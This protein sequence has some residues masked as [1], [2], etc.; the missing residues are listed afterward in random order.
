MSADRYTFAPP[1]DT[2]H[3]KSSDAG[4]AG[5]LSGFAASCMCM[6]SARHQRTVRTQRKEQEVM[7]LVLSVAGF[8]E[9][10]RVITTHAVKGIEVWFIV[11]CQC[12]V[13]T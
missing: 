4:S 6:R 7:G 9:P 5:L 10:V 11:N 2:T 3:A 12:W 8:G 13:V 1:N